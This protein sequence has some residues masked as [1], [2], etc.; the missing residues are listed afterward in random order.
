MSYLFIRAFSSSVSNSKYL[1]FDTPNSKKLPPSSVLNTIIFGIDEQCNLIFETALFTNCRTYII[2]LFK[3]SPLSFLPIISFSL[4]FLSSLILA[5][6]SMF[7]LSLCLTSLPPSPTKPRSEHLAM[8]ISITVVSFFSFIFFCLSLWF[9]VRFGSGYV[10]YGFGVFG[11][12]LMCSGDFIGLGSWVYVRGS[13]T[14]LV[15]IVELTDVDRR[16]NQPHQ[17]GSL[18]GRGERETVSPEREDEKNKNKKGIK[19]YKE[20]IF[21]WICK[22]KKK[23]WCSVYYKM[24]R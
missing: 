13:S 3:W 16:L 20:I 15:W 17:R 11:R 14:W 9:D 24:R 6:I 21:K 1:A 18:R 8:P 19:N 22:K 23:F 5:P 4:L 12:G 10:G 2:F 7:S